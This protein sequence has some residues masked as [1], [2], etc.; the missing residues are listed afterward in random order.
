M[1]GEVKRI[2]SGRVIENTYHP[3]LLISERGININHMYT[4][5][6]K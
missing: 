6:P 5:I 4:K 3:E 2:E 1:M